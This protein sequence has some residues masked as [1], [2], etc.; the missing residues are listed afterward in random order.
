MAIKDF[1][2]ASARTA[3]A[4]F[5]ALLALTIAIAGFTWGSDKYEKQQAKPFETVKEWKINLKEPLSLDLSARTK[6]VDGR[7]LAQ[8]E[9]TGFPPYLSAP[10][11]RDAQFTIEF[12]DS[13]GFSVFVKPIKVSAF[14]KIVGKGDDVAGLS[15]QFDDYLAA[16]ASC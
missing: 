13:D 11:N 5:L 4:I 9:V 10:K 15:H 12:V 7:L 8:I 3:V 14:T 2:K 16:I 6:L 1:L